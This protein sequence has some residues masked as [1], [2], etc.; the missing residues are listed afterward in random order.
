MEEVMF[1]WTGRKYCQKCSLIGWQWCHCKPKMRLQAEADAAIEDRLHEEK[2]EA[3][4][5]GY[6]RW[7]EHRGYYD[8]TDEN[9]PPQTILAPVG[10]YDGG[11]LLPGCHI[12]DDSYIVYQEI[13]NQ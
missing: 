6:D 9:P 8:C 13:P 12:L 1:D 10:E 5:W 3:E 4:V 7:I 11:D 2:N